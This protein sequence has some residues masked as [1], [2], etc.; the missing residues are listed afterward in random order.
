MRDT[1]QISSVTYHLESTLK[2]CLFIKYIFSCD[3]KEDPCFGER[4]DRW[5]EGGIFQ[6][7]SCKH[8]QKIFMA[9]VYQRPVVTA[10]L[11][12]SEDTIA[13]SQADMLL[14]WAQYL[15][16]GYYVNRFSKQLKRKKVFSV[17]LCCFLDPRVLMD[18]SRISSAVRVGMISACT[19]SLMHVSQWISQR[20]STEYNRT[21]N[22]NI[23]VF[24]I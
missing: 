13:Q 12:G 22:Y 6:T 16:A 15:W 1:D 9:S 7:Y 19:I 2:P 18:C 23:R 5:M 11:K 17:C 20:S 10:I 8:N 3:P 24:K 21:V 14:K 4:M